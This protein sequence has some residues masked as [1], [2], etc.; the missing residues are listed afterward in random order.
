VT[1][2]I[3]GRHPRFVKG[4]INSVPVNFRPDLTALSA[5]NISHG[6][7]G[8][9][10]RSPKGPALRAL[11]S[12]CLSRTVNV[13]TRSRIGVAQVRSPPRTNVIE[14]RAGAGAS[15]CFAFQGKFAACSLPHPRPKAIAPGLCVERTFAEQNPVL[16][17]YRRF[18][19]ASSSDDVAPSAGALCAD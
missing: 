19:G 15:A 8:A 1:A 3:A 7:R 12:R 9:I 2:W 13:I 17:A 10:S 14:T 11:R 18:F 6:G 16:T 4:D 5:P